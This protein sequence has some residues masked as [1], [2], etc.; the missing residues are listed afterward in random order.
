MFV[1]IGTLV[2]V[3]ENNHTSVE[4][5]P[6]SH[7]ALVAVGVIQMTVFL[8]CHLTGNCHMNLSNIAKTGNETT[9]IVSARTR[10]TDGKKSSRPRHMFGQGTQHRCIGP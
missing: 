7:D 5:L 6:G 3:P 8:E 4:L 2:V 9:I 10:G 1:D